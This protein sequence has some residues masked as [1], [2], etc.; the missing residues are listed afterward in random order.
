MAEVNVGTSWVFMG[1]SK[2]RKKHHTERPFRF[3]TAWLLDEE[4]EKVVKDAWG[5]MEGSSVVERLQILLG[6]EVEQQLLVAH[7]EQI[8]EVRVGVD[9]LERK[10]DSLLEKQ[11]A[12]W[13]LRSRHKASQRKRCNYIHGLMDDEGIW[14]ENEAKVESIITNYISN[15]FSSTCPSQHDINAVLD[16]R[17][18]RAI[19]AIPLSE[20]RLGD[21][22]TWA[23]SKDGN[24]TLS[25]KLGSSF[26]SWRLHPKCDISFGKLVLIFYQHLIEDNTFPLCKNK[27]ESIFHALVDCPNNVWVTCGLEDF[28]QH[29][30]D[31]CFCDWIEELYNRDKRKLAFLAFAL[32]NLWFRSNKVVFEGK[33]QSNELVIERTRRIVTEFGE[34]AKIIYGHPTVSRTDSPKVWQALLEGVVKINADASL[35]GEGWI[36]MG[37]VA[38]GA[39]GSV[40]WAISRRVKAW[41]SAEIAEGKALCLALNMARE[42]NHTHIIMESDCQHIINRLSKGDFCLSDLD[43]ILDDSFA[44]S[45][46]FNAS[47]VSCALGGQ[48]GCS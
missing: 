29:E 15:L 41:W 20:R 33:A 12:Y 47:L 25:T 9:E 4:C 24:Y 38:R 35:D 10:L 44:L 32:W 7:R 31:A 42:Q 43:S 16:E 19:L 36:G 1:G 28:A 39:D 34:Y 26:E 46:E 14:H 22:V 17:D 37:A 23:F 5:N 13:Y 18:Q 6:E 21:W 2:Q 27:P 8:D 40:L 11:E 45:K 3:E 48:C 30:G